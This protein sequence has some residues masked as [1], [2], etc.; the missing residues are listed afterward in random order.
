[1]KRFQGEKSSFS[2]RFLCEA[3]SLAFSNRKTLLS[4]GGQGRGRGMTGGRD[5]KA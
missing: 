1:M 5:R 3:A 4:D 2:K